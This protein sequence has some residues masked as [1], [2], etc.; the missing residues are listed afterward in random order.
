MFVYTSL[1]IYESGMKPSACISRLV[2]LGPKRFQIVLPNLFAL[3]SL[4]AVRMPSRETMQ[5]GPRCR[6][7]LIFIIFCFYSPQQQTF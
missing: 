7:Y 5:S 2:Y 4:M 6:T 3:Q 1:N